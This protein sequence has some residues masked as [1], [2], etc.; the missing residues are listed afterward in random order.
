[1]DIHI[2]GKPANRPPWIQLLFIFR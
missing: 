1:M 2:R